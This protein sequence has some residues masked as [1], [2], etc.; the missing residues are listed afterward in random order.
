MYRFIVILSLALPLVA[1]ADAS[2]PQSTAAPATEQAAA[3]TAESLVKKHLAACGGEARLRSAKSMKFT[4][5]G[6][7]GELEL[8][9]V[10]TQRPNQFRKEVT[11]GG[12]TFVKAFDGAAGF[13][14]EDSKVTTLADD[15]AAMMK[16]HADFDDALLDYQAKG[17][18]VELKGIEDV[19]G[20]KAYALQV[21]MKGGEVENRYLDASTFLEIKRVNSWEHEGK[22]E[23]K[24]TYFSDYRKVDGIQVNHV[25]ET[26]GGGKKGKLLI[27]EVWFDRPMEA[28]LFRRPES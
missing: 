26:E 15:K 4:A 25:I 2:A 20:T 24:I 8:L 12:K 28:S 21:T 17:H 27:Q 11:K 23:E 5:K 10:Y 13:T 7:E 14:I 18:K 19:R 6:A 22:K 16:Q 3:E 1:C 9:T